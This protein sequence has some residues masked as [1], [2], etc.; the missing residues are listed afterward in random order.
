MAEELGPTLLT[1]FPPL[2]SCEDDT[3]SSLSL[4]S[5]NTVATI[6]EFM[7]FVVED[8]FI[9][10]REAHFLVHGSSQFVSMLL[11]DSKLEGRDTT[12]PP[13]VFRYGGKK[14][15]KISGEGD[16]NNRTAGQTTSICTVAF[17]LLDETEG[18]AV[19][20]SPLDDAYNTFIN[21]ILAQSKKKL[22]LILKAHVQISSSEPL[23]PPPTTT[24]TQETSL[25]SNV[26]V[27]VHNRKRKS[28]TFADD[29]QIP[30]RGKSNTESIRISES[31]NLFGKTC[32]LYFLTSLIIVSMHYFIAKMEY[33]PR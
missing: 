24:T 14:K 13:M 25:S 23:P 26:P 8:L 16:Y 1:H 15:N 27:P 9:G 33:L 19:I 4:S 29:E 2:R 28:I 11:G 31:F 20:I 32:S 7:Q 30:K 18:N 17:S 6:S 22:D 12:T 5:F 10:N 3:S 21:L